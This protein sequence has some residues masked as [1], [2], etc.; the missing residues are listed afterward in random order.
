MELSLQLAPLKTGENALSQEE[1]DA[2]YATFEQRINTSG[3][4][5]SLLL[6]HTFRQLSDINDVTRVLESLIEHGFIRS[7]WIFWDGDDCHE[8]YELDEDE[9]AELVAELNKSKAAAE[10]YERLSDEYI[11]NCGRIVHPE[12]GTEGFD[13]LEHLGK[14]YYFT[15]KLKV[16]PALVEYTEHDKDAAMRELFP[17]ELLPELEVL[18]QKIAMK[19][20]GL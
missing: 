12:K 13:P 14:H 1:Y 3:I 7:E 5:G 11:I 6:P 2:V 19:R 16:D 20:L 10:K 15:D 8:F 9:E 4:E 18:S 17:A